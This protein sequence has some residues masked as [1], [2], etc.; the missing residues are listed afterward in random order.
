MKLQSFTKLGHVLLLFTLLL[1]VSG[2]ALGQSNGY[3]SA[4]GGSSSGG[5][6]PGA[7]SVI[8]IPIT[9]A[10][11]Q[12]SATSIPASA[13]VLR[14]FLD[15]VTPYSV[16]ATITVGTAPSHSAFMNTGASNPQIAAIYDA[17]QDTANA[18][19]NPFLVTVA[20]S[21]VAGAGFAC[22]EYS[23]PQN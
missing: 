14:A 10:A 2:I 19:S 23:L 12:T 18:A 9:N 1:A 13:I 8:R 11:S 17:P 21:P 7:V 6:T 16:G 5:S 22:V 4:G 20:G 3:S 15:V